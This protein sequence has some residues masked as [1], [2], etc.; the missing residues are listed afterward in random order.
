MNNPAQRLIDLT[1]VVISAGLL[2]AGFN[3]YTEPRAMKLFPVGHIVST[4]L[5]ASN[6]AK[7][8]SAAALALTKNMV[9]HKLHDYE[10]TATELHQARKSMFDNPVFEKE[11]G[12]DSPRTSGDS[13]GKE[14]PRTSGDSKALDI[15]YGKAR[16]ADSGRKK[17]FQDLCAVYMRLYHAGLRIVW[18]WGAAWL[19]NSKPVRALPVDQEY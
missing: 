6:I 7:P 13:E 2:T 8:L 16:V 12:K 17:R 19:L 5:N 4:L 14:S 1:V 18:V 15:D 3:L 10:K 11:P 9:H